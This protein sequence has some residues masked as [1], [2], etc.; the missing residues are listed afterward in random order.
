[1][2][3]ASVRQTKKEMIE[4]DLAIAVMH[5]ANFR[6]WVALLVTIILLVAS[7]LGWVYYESQFVETDTS[8]LDVDQESESGS[9]FFVGRDGDNYNGTTASPN[10]QSAP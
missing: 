9:N 4:R 2:T 6:L 8:F 5:K 3:N 1:M 10:R 7:N